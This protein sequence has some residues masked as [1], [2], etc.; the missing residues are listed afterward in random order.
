MSFPSSLPLAGMPPEAATPA[1]TA[2]F[3]PYGVSH[4]MALGVVALGAVF[5]VLFGRRR[6]VTAARRMSRWMC[7]ALLCFELPLQIYSMLP[8]Q[9]DL[10][11]SLPFQFSDLAGMAAA[12]A[13]WSHDRRAYAL[14]YYW[15]LTLTPQALFT[16]DL[17]FD[18]PHLQFAMFW[19]SHGLV[20]WAAITMTW[21]LGF[22]PDWQSY[23]LAVAVSGT[24][25]VLM[26]AFNFLAGTDYLY[27]N[28]KP[29]VRSLLDLLGPWPWYLLS[30]AA[31]ASIVWA[32]LTL[33][34]CAGSRRQ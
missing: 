23:R 30:E 29:A 6:R 9:W 18:F 2:R 7:G 25:L 34:W 19:G 1:T 3:V 10:A 28:G 12:W 4:W 21:G 32:L 27:S 13:L 17:R 26:L 8:P 5:L 20:L 15:G 24:W 14:L 33:P 16:P 31:M 11:S 22:R